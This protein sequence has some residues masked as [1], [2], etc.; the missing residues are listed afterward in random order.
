MSRLVSGRII[1][2]VVHVMDRQPVGPRQHPL[3]LLALRDAGRLVLKDR[4]RSSEERQADASPVPPPPPRNQTVIVVKRNTTRKVVNH[5]EL[6]DAL[7]AV[8]LRVL[9]SESPNPDDPDSWI[10]G[11]R[12]WPLA[13]A[14]VAAHGAGLTN[15]A[16]MAPGAALIEAVPQ[17]HAALGFYYFQLA[18]Y[19]RLRY[20]HLITPGTQGSDIAVDVA[21][22]L[23]TVCGMLVCK[24][25]Y[26]QRSPWPFLQP[27]N[28]SSDDHR[29]EGCEQHSRE[30]KSR[31]P[32]TAEEP[33]LA[34]TPLTRFNFTHA[35]KAH[36]AWM[37][38]EDRLPLSKVRG[39][40]LLLGA[41]NHPIGFFGFEPSMHRFI[42]VLERHRLLAVHWPNSMTE[43][44]KQDYTDNCTSNMD[45]RAALHFTQEILREV[46]IAQR[47]TEDARIPL[48][49]YGL[50][51]GGAFTGV[52]ASHIQVDASVV[53]L[54]PPTALLE[55]LVPNSHN[56][57]AGPVVL[58]GGLQGPDDACAFVPRSLLPHRVPA[59]WITSA[60]LNLQETVE[61]ERFRKELLKTG[62][63]PSRVV[64][65]YWIPEAVTHASLHE[66]APWLL[67]PTAGRAI[68]DILHAVGLLGVDPKAL[69]SLR[70][71]RDVCGDRKSREKAVKDNLALGGPSFHHLL[72]KQNLDAIPAWRAAELA[73]TAAVVISDRP[74]VLG[75]PMLFA[76]FE[77][78]DF[79]SHNSAPHPLFLRPTTLQCNKNIYGRQSSDECE[80]LHTVL[81]W[82][83]RWLRTVQGDHEFHDSPWEDI[84]EWYLQQS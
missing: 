71:Y 60:P 43:G 16:F 35:G 84:V 14:V 8:G 36:F 64:G 81:G 23:W 24:H 72:H 17:G 79:P 46:R 37:T 54:V 76:A 67:S 6:V 62:V 55:H 73:I 68:V 80:V 56:S 57:D 82:L 13:G 32:L 78:P 22:I 27:R 28:A 5:K 20:H 44:L 61:L 26:P 83:W 42:R 29:Q 48:Y 2:R 45:L 31:V 10:D 38:P 77:D 7:T 75:R 21:G 9:V 41:A 74:R 1:A 40:A 12:M 30:A 70:S 51:S 34:Q 39:I 4:L 18:H 66:S 50:S 3:Q 63:P 19:M 25:P 52:L 59:F 49:T 58:D 47:L 69:A 15:A 53:Q 11:L 33:I 65:N